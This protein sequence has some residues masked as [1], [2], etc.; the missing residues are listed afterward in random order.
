M[1]AREKLYLALTKELLGPRGTVNEFIE[2]D[3]R[4]EYVT[5]V[6]EPQS[7]SREDLLD[8]GIPDIGGFVP[9]VEGD[10]DTEELTDYFLTSP[11]S[12]TLHPLARP[13]T[14]GISFI[15]SSTQKPSINLCITWARYRTHLNGW[16]REPF[17]HIITAVDLASGML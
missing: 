1:P 11:V 3:P 7:V 2:D 15:V 16:R 13:K 12:T 9:S 14:M 6:L 17:Y 5:G 10:E 8:Y 4:D